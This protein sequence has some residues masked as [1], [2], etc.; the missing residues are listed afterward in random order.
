V[1]LNKT[2]R[3][4]NHQNQAPHRQHPPFRLRGHRSMLAASGCGASGHLN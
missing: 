3:D 2:T 4:R 1:A